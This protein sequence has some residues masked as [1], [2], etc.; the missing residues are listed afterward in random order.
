MDIKKSFLGSNWWKTQPAESAKERNK[1]RP[2]SAAEPRR[3]PTPRPEPEA[4]ESPA[5]D[6]RAKR[7]KT[8]IPSSQPN[9]NPQPN[10]IQTKKQDPQPSSEEP[11]KDTMT[12][13]KTTSE[14]E[15]F[16]PAGVVIDGTIKGDCPLTIYGKVNGNIESSSEVFIASEGEVQ[17]DIKCAKIEICGFVKGTVVA[18]DE[19]SI[20]RGGKLIGQLTTPNLDTESGATF[21]GSV[22]MPEPKK[23]AEIVSQKASSKE[24][25]HKEDNNLGRRNG[26][27]MASSQE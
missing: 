7:L 17:S 4:T 16:I 19:V 9:A 23:M 11:R 22:E 12:T 13:N 8:E 18:V 21:N 25:E 10:P 26:L 14:K 6:R 3:K 20:R 27:S 2:Q 24:E 15:A 5:P 1:E